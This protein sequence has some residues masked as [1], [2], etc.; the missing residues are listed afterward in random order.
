MRVFLLNFN[1][2]DI[3]IEHNNETKEITLINDKEKIIENNQNQEE[4]L[5]E[6]ESILNESNNFYVYNDELTNRKYNIYIKRYDKEF[7]QT[8]LPKETINN[9]QEFRNW[10]LIESYLY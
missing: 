8:N 7:H 5:K 6:T 9:L 2:K 3:K 1:K 10:D 4:D